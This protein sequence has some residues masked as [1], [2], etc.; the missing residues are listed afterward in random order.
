MEYEPA[1][2]MLNPEQIK[3]AADNIGTFDTDN[4]SFLFQDGDRDMMEEAA[5]FKNGKDYRG[6]VKAFSELPQE[7]EGFTDEQ[8][9]AWFDE[10][11]RK[12]KQAANSREQAEGTTGTETA[13]PAE[14]DREF[15]ELI[16]EPGDLED[17]VK[18]LATAYNE[19]YGQWQAAD[20]EDAANRDRWAEISDNLRRKFTH[21]TWQSI[22]KAGG[23]MGLTQQK[24]VLTMIRN[25]PREYR[26]IYADITERPDMAV[27]AEDSTAAA[28]KHRITDSRRQDVDSLT[29]EKMR[30]LAEQLDIEDFAE[31]VRTGHAQFD[32]PVERAYIKQLQDQ[33]RKLEN[34]LKEID[35]DR[36]EDNNFIE[37][38]AGK[39]FNDAFERAIKAHE[40]ITRKHSELDRAIKEGRRS[41]SRIAWQLQ[42][43]NANYNTIIQSLE[44]LA[45]AHQLELDIQK[46]L[47]DEK[48]KDYAKSAK[49]EATLTVRLARKAERDQI[50]T[51]IAEIKKMQEAAKELTQAKR[52]VTRRILRP[53]NPREVN[54]EQGR[55]VAIIQRLVEPSMLEGI[56]RFIGGIEKPYLRTIFETWKVDEQLRAGILKNKAQATADKMT[57]ILNKERFEDLTNGERKYLYLKIP[58]NDW[59]VAL[60]L[61]SI[62]K[63]RNQNFPMNGETEQQIAL[64]YLAPDLYYR[65]MDKPFSEWTLEEG[66]E[67]AKVIDDLIVQGKEV[68]KANI[69]AEQKRIGAYQTSVRNTIRTVNKAG[70]RPEEIEKIIGRYDYGVAGTAAADAK[71]RASKGS[72]LGYADMNIYR[73]ARM[74]DNG[75]ANGKNSAALYRRASDA[76][77]QEMTVVDYRTERIQKRMKELGI[78]DKELW[79][80]TAELN[81]GG[82]LGIKPFTAAELLGFLSATRDDYSREAVLYGNMLTENERAPYQR[83]NITNME[84]TPMYEIAEQ[85]YAQV[86]A[87]AQ[88]IIADNPNYQ[89]LMDAI[90]EDF[91]EG[92]QRL[93][94]A[95]VRYNNTYMP[96]VDKY[97]PIHRQAAVNINSADAQLA[98]D[99]MGGSSGAFNLFVEKGFTNERQNIPAQY[100]TAI[101]LDILGVWAEA[102]SREEHFMAYGQLIKDLNAIYKQNRPVK[103]AIQRRYGQQAVDYINKYINELANPNHEKTRSAIDNFVRSMRGN[104]AAAYLSWKVSGIA[105][106]FITSPAPFFAY[107]N[108]LEYWGTFIEYAAHQET[109][110]QEITQLSPHMAH[111]SANLLVEMV[112][113][114]A[115]QKFDNKA[116]SAI[117]RFNQKGM[118]GLTWIDRM[119]VAPGWLVLYRKEYSKLTNNPANA[120]MNEKDIRVKAAQYAD[121]II[122]LTQPSARADDLAPLFK[123]NNELG[124]ALLQFTASLNVI[125]QNARYDLPQMIRERRYKNAAGTIIGYTLAGIML[126][127]ITAGFDDDDD[128][129]SKMKKIAWWATTQ[130]TDSFPI[131]GSEMTRLAEY[132]ITG[133]MRYQGGMNLLPIFQKIWN[134][135]AA[136][137]KGL[138]EKDFEKLLKASAQAAEALGI[139]KG[140]PVSGIKEAGSLLGIGDEEEGLNLNPGALTGRR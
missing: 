105:K 61:E 4:P 133:K 101:K 129:A 15:I 38:L 8:I 58:P 23:R 89:K 17:F 20:E 108:P 97:F 86:E 127:A 29:P 71:R 120:N 94:E 138:Q 36:Q 7:V 85:R 51:H 91:T 64:K 114:N 31:K 134:A 112:K 79:Q 75:D 126:G 54:A 77:N 128:E 125:W 14:L 81:L 26:A 35:D 63:R 110:W 30:Q 119:C 72:L 11:V 22:F 66:E 123:G 59:A 113:E 132:S 3:S 140:L 49:T 121:D 24:Q 82:D 87:A 9:D 41:T 92:G 107:M 65:I 44:A 37:R 10:F 102:A 78:T 98:R 117:S 28:L 80:K 95:L 21:P 122:R 47:S 56:D 104:T 55:A 135:T 96:I 130:F 124:K 1:I 100:Q 33:R 136:T 103:D 109:T 57:R 25:S 5:G 13:T 116:D 12:A 118:E 88:K 42:R 19:D 50:R 76:Y 70:L 27:S 60:G 69:D 90:D 115:K 68:Y 62:I 137:A 2:M 34:D 48:L 111:R 106:Q 32:D 73:F 46:I 18:L 67:L 84:L 74:L 93:S 40:Q 99:L 6:Y 16:S 139:Y 52:G 43:Q 45:S 83:K 39:E 53:I 131:I